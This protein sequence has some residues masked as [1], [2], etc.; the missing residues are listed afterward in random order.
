VGLSFY[1]QPSTFKK[2]EKDLEATTERMN[3]RGE[4]KE[5][6]SLPHTHSF[7][8]MFDRNWKQL[9]PIPTFP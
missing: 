6:A 7:P 9:P 2:L 5:N 4:K 8:T 1:Y 3:T